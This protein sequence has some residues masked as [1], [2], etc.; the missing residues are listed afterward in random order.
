M[1]VRQ[2]GQAMKRGIEHV[3]DLLNY[4]EGSHLLKHYF[5]YHSFLKIS[6]V[7]FGMKVRSTFRSP[8][9]RQI[10]E[11]VAIDTEKR[12]GKKSMNSKSEYNRCTI[13]KTTTKGKIKGT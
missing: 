2:E 11:A 1:L 3:R 13:P 7:K 5:S 10:G 12:K 4:D 8:L 6:D 9:E